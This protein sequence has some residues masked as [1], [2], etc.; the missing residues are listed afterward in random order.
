MQVTQFG[1]LSFALN[2]DID[3]RHTHPVSSYPLALDIKLME[4]TFEECV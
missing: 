2:I 4:V 1:D 3:S